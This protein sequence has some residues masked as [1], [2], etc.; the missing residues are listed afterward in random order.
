MQKELPNIFDY[1]SYRKWLEDFCDAQKTLHTS[2]SFRSIAH[3]IGFA[4]PNYLQLV[5]Q[6]K[7]NLGN[8]SI[9]RIATTL[10]LGKKAARYFRLLV[11][12]GQASDITDKN[13]SFTAIIRFKN[14]ST[15]AKI[16]A[17]QFEYYSEWYHCVVRE[18]A[19]GLQADS[20][21]YANL[22][23]RV[24]PA[25]LPK[26]AKKSVA[27]LL[28][29]GFLYVNEQGL[30]GQASPFLTTDR[31][32]QSI[33]VRNFHDTMLNIAREAL[34][35]VPPESREIS[36]LTMRISEAGFEKIKTRIQDFKE[37]LMQIIRDDE[38]VDRVYQADFLFF[39]VSKTD[40]Q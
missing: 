7:R 24:Y 16:I 27:L 28:K 10:G 36:S 26:Q 40:G 32:T 3:K 37:E 30:F 6:G 11:D 33:A 31:E 23:R 9:S 34:V 1:T 25:I 20:I 15:A 35:N 14:R 19:A 38:N 8:E 17:D 4:S 13:R 2:F 5:I 29:L 39:P 18:L 22:A 21:D 12:F